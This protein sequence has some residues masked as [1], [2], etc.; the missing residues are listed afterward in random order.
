MSFLKT[1]CID[2]L[3]NNSIKTINESIRHINTDT[4]WHQHLD[5]KKVGIV[6]TSIALKFY[7]LTGKTCPEEEDAIKF[8]LNK[9]NNDG[10][11]P[12]ISNTPDKSNVESTCWAI[13]AL[14]LYE[15][16]YSNAI[17][18][19]VNWLLK[20][21]IKIN[22]SIDLGWGYI[23]EQPSRTYHTCIALRTLAKKPE[24]KAQEFESALQWLKNTQ[25][26]K[27]GWGES[28][29]RPASLFFTSY[30]VITLIECGT[31]TNAPSIIKALEWIENKIEEVGWNDASL[32][33]YL[34]F[35]EQEI[36]SRK[37]R[38]SFFHFTLPYIT[39]AFIKA[40]RQNSPIVFNSLSILKKK[41]LNGYWLHPFLED[42]SIKPIW[43]IYDAISSFIMFKQKKNNWGKIIY[44]RLFRGKIMSITRYN[45][46]RIIDSIGKKYWFAIR[47]FGGIAVFCLTA[48]WIYSYLSPDTNHR[49]GS[50]EQFIASIASSLIASLIFS[51]PNIIRYIN[52]K[53]GLFNSLL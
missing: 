32:T 47:L 2:D 17:T 23:N 1:A 31:E 38:L 10:G 49:F 35:I 40:G 28:N 44:F 16:K 34:E 22:Q 13:Q 11:W 36:D 12:Y 9:Q 21:I 37:S 43:A 29:G 30:A 14:S 4:G 42:S 52:K 53:L 20:H 26:S 50:I 19:G 15:D 41:N 8:I 48:F 3:I 39:M 5:A 46:F 18:K 6:A 25:D 33:C 45:P 27:G 24:N 51:F 7:S